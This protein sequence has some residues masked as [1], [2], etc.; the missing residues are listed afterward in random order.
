MTP[1][2]E[3]RGVGKTYAGPPA[4]TALRPFDLRIDHGDY[5]SVV[6]P[7]GSGKST[8]LNL[9]GL[10][11][12]PTEGEYLLDGAPTSGV[13][14]SARAALRATRI[15]F[16]FQAF[17]VLR[18]RTA[19]ENVMLGQLYQGERKSARRAAALSTL[20][21][22]GLAGRAEHTSAQLS[23]G[24]LQRVAIARA[25]V[26]RPSLLLCDEPT[27]NLDGESSRR[28]LAL[29]EEVHAG[30]QTVVIVTHDREV[31]A[32]AQR[33]INIRDGVVTELAP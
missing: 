12:R 21:R 1:V 27:G 5:V 13:A 24:E 10:L 18:A 7:S 19:V 25:L 29:L 16:V 32:R 2:I 8:W 6:G 33:T 28:I 26:A 31:A 22:V 11:D 30:G 20:E 17:H 15:G 4:V 3:F 23:G 9:C 14:E